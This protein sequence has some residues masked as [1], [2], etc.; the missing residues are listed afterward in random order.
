MKQIYEKDTFNGIWGSSNNVE[1]GYLYCCTLK[2]FKAS[3]RTHINTLLGCRIE[4]YCIISVEEW[5][6]TIKW[7]IERYEPLDGVWVIF[8]DWEQIVLNRVHR[9]LCIWWQFQDCYIIMCGG[10]REDRWETRRRY[11]VCTYSVACAKGM[12]MNDGL[13]VSVYISIP[14][15]RR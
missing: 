6:R 7:R 14:V 11:F 1:C 13:N 12:P 2:S 8:L 10:E 5:L 9:Y 15:P 4:Q 3:Q